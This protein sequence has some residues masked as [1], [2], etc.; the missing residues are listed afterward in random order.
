MFKKIQRFFPEEKLA[1]GLILSG[2]FLFFLW[3]LFRSEGFIGDADSVTHYRFSRYSW[4][5]P[6][7]L[8]DHWAKPVFTLLSSP[9][10]QFG[11]SGVSVF[12]LLGG[13]ASAWLAWLSA[14]KLGYS[15]RLLLPFFV[16][17]TPIYTLLVISG[18][19]EVLFG[20]FIIATVWL[21]LDKRY[22]WAAVV[23]SFSHLVRTEGI[24]IIPTIGLY[25]LIKRQYH[26]IPL[27]LTGTLIYSII[28]YFHF[29]DFFW[30]INQMPYGGKAEMYGT[31]SFWH[32]FQAWPKIFGKLNGWLMALGVLAIFYGL[33]R[34]KDSRHWGELIL[35]LM[36]FGLYFMAHVLM[37]YT[38]IGRSL[39]MYR[40][41]ISIVPLGALIALRGANV[42]LNGLE[43]L[44]KT[45]LP[46]DLLALV[47]LVFFILTPF[48]EW[49]IPQKLEGMN[50]VMKE[51]ADFV[52]E[53]KINQDKIY[54][55]DPAL[56]M[57]LHL[58][59]YDE[60][61]SRLRLPDS[62]KPHHEVIPGEIIIWEGHFMAL[63]GVKLEDLKHS[64]YFEQLGLF[65]PEHP[66]TIFETD[67]KV[68][69]F[70]RLDVDENFANDSFV[71]EK[72][73][74]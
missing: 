17:F 64:P 66:F 57:F 48:N 34:K 27:L 10:A 67:Y 47:M 50:K 28:G 7:F 40:Y 38:G 1:L 37:W 8:L 73:E 2:L 72:G 15:N 55:S 11:H 63:E 5:F 4:Q 31:G 26:A 61:T 18:Q 42:A 30:L 60:T 58:N 21:C 45:K 41:M 20:L 65:E 9:F 70:R 25:F 69:I 13:I 29:K 6:S 56:E 14:K 19:V 59:P 33:L 22:L 16:F 68:A 44:F 74:D 46:S 54:Y 52:L 43:G 39:G 36:P 49:R 23:I 71:P 24:I 51:A 53:N 32:F 62:S 35:I 3:I 12:N